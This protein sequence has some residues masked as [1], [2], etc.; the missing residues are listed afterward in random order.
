MHGATLLANTYTPGIAAAIE[1]S[2]GTGA[3]ALLRMAIDHIRSEFDLTDGQVDSVMFWS[4]TGM[5]SAMLRKATHM[6]CQ[7][8]A[9]L[10][11]EVTMRQ[12]QVVQRAEQE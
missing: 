3:T 5:A 2:D 1:R 9:D 8:P 7:S 10:V 11:A 4:M 6:D 12:H